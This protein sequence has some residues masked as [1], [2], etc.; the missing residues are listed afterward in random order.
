MADALHGQAHLPF[1]KKGVCMMLYIRYIVSCVILGILAVLVPLAL[2][3]LNI[4]FRQDLTIILL[5]IFSSIVLCYY[6]NFFVKLVVLKLLKYKINGINI[7]PM[8]IKKSDI[9]I[10]L[11]IKK[12]LGPSIL[13]SLSEIASYESL[14][15]MTKKNDRA[16]RLL[17]E[18]RASVVLI[19]C[20]TL[21]TMGL[22][23]MYFIGV[24]FAYVII[25]SKYKRMQL[26]SYVLYGYIQILSLTKE[27]NDFL[28]N[29]C[30]EDF[31]RIFQTDFQSELLIQGLFSLEIYQLSSNTSF[32][33]EFD[34]SIQ[35]FLQQ[36]LLNDAELISVLLREILFQYLVFKFKLSLLKE[37]NHLQYLSYLEYYIEKEWNVAIPKKYVE[38][39]T[40]IKEISREEIDFSNLDYCLFGLSLF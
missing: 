2:V 25:Y 17:N 1:I 13:Y 21:Y 22:W 3:G 27:Q 39:F 28:V 5:G 30:K 37:L 23:M 14:D 15:D 11:N 10:D 18:I 24:C 32:D 6:I 40:E 4:Y 33:K 9:H 34:R 19:G 31:I 7:F 12:Y 38:T 36:L 16:Y 35:K 20:I 26:T 8:R 29:A